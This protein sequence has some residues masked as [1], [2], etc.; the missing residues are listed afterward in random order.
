[1]TGLGTWETTT[2]LAPA[3]CAGLGA[4]GARENADRE[5]LPVGGV[6][7]LGVGRVGIHETWGCPRVLV[8][9]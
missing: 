1:M 6:T 7:V 5:Q 8:C 2:P 4:P 9:S 3:F